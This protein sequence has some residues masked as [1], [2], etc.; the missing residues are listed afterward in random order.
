PTERK[1]W[2]ASN[3]K[4]VEASSFHRA[5]DIAFFDVSFGAPFVDTIRLLAPFSRFFRQIIDF[6]TSCPE[7]R[8]D[9]Y[10]VK[11]ARAKIKMDDIPKGSVQGL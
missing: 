10:D 2:T 11:Q 3:R 5:V 1:K 4:A 6:P 9:V 8:V 7:E